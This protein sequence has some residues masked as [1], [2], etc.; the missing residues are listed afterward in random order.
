MWLR[1]E[2]LYIPLTRWLFLTF[3][4]QFTMTDYTDL[5]ESILSAKENGNHKFALNQF[6][7]LNDD[8]RKRFFDFCEDLLYYDAADA[9]CSTFMAD[10]IYPYFLTPSYSIL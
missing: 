5:F 10:D 3:L 9:G 2:N 8:Q 4:N 7:K 6:R 1:I